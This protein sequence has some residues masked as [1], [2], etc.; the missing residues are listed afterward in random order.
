MASKDLAS[1]VERAVSDGAFLNLL[2][3]DPGRALRGYRL[4]DEERDAMLSGDMARLQSLGVAPAAFG[5]AAIRGISS[6]SS[7]RR[8]TRWSS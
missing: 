3:R 4:T 1:A 2:N 5:G 8:R 6:A 7:N